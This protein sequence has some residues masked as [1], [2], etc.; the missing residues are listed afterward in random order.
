MVYG[1]DTNCCDAPA[2][3][4]MIVKTKLDGV[5]ATYR[6]DNLGITR[7]SFFGKNIEKVD[8]NET[9]GKYYSVDSDLGWCSGA[10]EAVDAAADYCE[11]DA[12]TPT[13]IYSGFGKAK[14]GLTK[15]TKAGTCGGGTEGCDPD[16]IFQSYKGWFAGYYPIADSTDVKDYS[17][18][19]G[20]DWAIYGGTWSAKYNKKY[21]KL[22]SIT[23]KYPVACE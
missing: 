18:E 23:T 12:N 16:V 9:A 11:N 19:S 10:R 7:L 15:G 2:S 5:T 17:C 6:Y 22:S 1:S 13:F 20:C 4:T 8:A 21:T 3:I 14:M